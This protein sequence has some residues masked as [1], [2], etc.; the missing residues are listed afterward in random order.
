MRSFND[1]PLFIQD[2]NS[3]H[4]N[5]VLFKPI[6]KVGKSKVIR[7]DNSSKFIVKHL[8]TWIR[9]VGIEPIQI[10][11]RLPWGNGYHERFNGKLRHEF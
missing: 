2:N 3:T 9:Q 7:S 4:L 5:H 11:K 8:Q 6:L 1:S 10:S